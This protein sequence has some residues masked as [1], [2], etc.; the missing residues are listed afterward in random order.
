METAAIAREATKRGVPF[1]AFRATSDGAGDPLMLPGFPSEFFVYYRLAAHNAAAAAIAFLE[2]FGHPTNGAPA[3]GAS[4]AQSLP[5][6]G[7]AAHD[8]EACAP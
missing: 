7:L 3:S 2:H 6:C 8:G 4:A 5:S 1:I